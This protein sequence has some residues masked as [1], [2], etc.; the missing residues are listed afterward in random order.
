MKLTSCFNRQDVSHCPFC[1]DAALRS[2]CERVL[3]SFQTKPH[4]REST[5]KKGSNSMGDLSLGLPPPHTQRLCSRSENEGMPL[6]TTPNVAKAPVHYWAFVG[7]S[8][9]LRPGQ[10]AP[11]DE[12]VW[13]AT[14]RDLPSYAHSRRSPPLCN[15]SALRRLVMNRKSPTSE[16]P[17]FSRS[18]HPSRGILAWGN[19]TE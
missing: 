8:V 14:V 13:T 15:E 9:P 19:H 17:H 2:I 18:V 16:F 6:T 10:A 1:Q 3:I 4:E 12:W 11:A 7:F 5:C